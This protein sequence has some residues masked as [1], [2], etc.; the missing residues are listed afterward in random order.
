[1]QS[2]QCS[3]D[4][5]GVI[6]GLDW[7]YAKC[8]SWKRAGQGR[9]TSSALG[10]VT[11]THRHPVQV[12]DY[13]DPVPGLGCGEV[14]N[15]S[16]GSCSR[17]IHS[18]MLLM[19]SGV[20]CKIK[21]RSWLPTLDCKSDKRQPWTAGLRC[22][23]AHALDRFRREQ[24]AV[25]LEQRLRLLR[26]GQGALNARP[27]PSRLRVAQPVQLLQR[28]AQLQ[29]ELFYLSSKHVDGDPVQLLHRRGVTCKQSPI[30]VVVEDPC[31]GS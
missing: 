24:V 22:A 21:Q 3:Q 4:T 28:R 27:P 15:L 20:F 1:M 7:T 19:A 2:S 9:S 18:R 26:A 10:A 8:Q 11:C 13:D 23:L 5:A 30:P 16:V 17:V 31:I 25:E 14:H 29:A 6:P 12:K